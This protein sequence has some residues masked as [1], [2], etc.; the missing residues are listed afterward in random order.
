MMKKL[1]ALILTLCLC[2]SCVGCDNTQ[3]KQSEAKEALQKVF[4]KEENFNFKSLISDD[5]TSENLNKFSFHTPYSVFNVFMP[6]GYA[7]VDFDSDGIDEMLI[8][9]MLLTFFLILKYDGQNVNGYIIDNISPQQVWVDG[10]FVTKAHSGYTTVSRVSFN[11]L[12]I[13]KSN[14]AFIS[15]SKKIYQI[16]DKTQ[17]KEK[18]QK[19]IDD[20][21]ENTEKISWVTVK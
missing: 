21:N 14:L 15:D 17:P 20:W 11:G 2:L 16:N 10:S 9:D 12:E 13:K 19:F 7:Y 8:V 4:E 5:V 6:Q 1:V 3:K 18:V